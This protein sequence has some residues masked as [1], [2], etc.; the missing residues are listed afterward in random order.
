MGAKLWRSGKVSPLSLGPNQKTMRILWICSTNPS[1]AEDSLLLALSGMN[2]QVARDILEA[3]EFLV[4]ALPYDAAIAN[5]PMI[6]LAAENVIEEITSARKGTAVLIRESG[7]GLAEAIHCTKIG[8]FHYFDDSAHP[9]DILDAVQLAKSAVRRAAAVEPWRQILVGESRPMLDLAERIR[10]VGSR[11]STVLISGE[12]GT[13]KELVARA[14]HMASTRCQQPLVTV[15]CSALPENLLEAELFGHVRG[16]FTGAVTS[17]VGRFEQANRGT[18]FLDEIADMPLDIQTKLLRVLQEREFQ[19]LGSSETIKVDVRVI[20]ACNVNLADRIRQGRF[21]EDLFYRLNVIPLELPALRERAADIPLLVQHFLEKI[22]RQEGIETRRVAAETLARLDGYYW[23]GNIRQLENAVEM[24][25]ALSGER[26]ILYPSDF[27]LPPAERPM[28]PAAIPSN[29]E[30]MITVPDA[31]LDFEQTVGTI[32]R[33]ILEQA[34]S[35]TGGNK[36]AAADM[37]RLKR[38]TLSA[39]L[40]ALDAVAV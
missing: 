21:R 6:G 12:T 19:R 33:S 16:A 2:V 26:E 37:L 7:G 38:T 11:R 34:L 10:L 20:A 28:Q 36:K 13:G 24:A 14:I 17:R 15:N 32:A 18:I 29:A 39:K 1:E 27:P 3:R 23:P 31:G 9:K 22:C 35:K 5:L 40:R 8:A 4:G 25:V 30:S